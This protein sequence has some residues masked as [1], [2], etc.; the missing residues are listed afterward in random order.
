[1]FLPKCDTDLIFVEQKE[2]SS[3]NLLHLLQRFYMLIQNQINDQSRQSLMGMLT[4]L[5]VRTSQYVQKTILQLR[6]LI[7]QR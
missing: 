1:M 6:C 3:L 2:H 5:S 4:S 7:L